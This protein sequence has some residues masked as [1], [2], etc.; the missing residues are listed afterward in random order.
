M[1]KR[2]TKKDLEA[3]IT[4]LHSHIKRIVRGDK[5]LAFEYRITYAHEDAVFF[6]NAEPYKKGDKVYFN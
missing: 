3:E 6:G 4:K 5:M 1:A 2:K